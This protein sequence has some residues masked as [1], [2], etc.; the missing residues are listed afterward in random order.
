MLSSASVTVQDRP[1]QS[2]VLT[3][4]AVIDMRSAGVKPDMTVVISGDRILALGK[5]SDVSAPQ[6]ATVIDASGKFLIPGLWDM[7]VHTVYDKADDTEKTLLPLFI[8]NGVTGIRN[9]GSINSLEQIKRWRTTSAEGKLIGPRILIGQQIDGPGG[10]NV[11]FVYRVKSESEAQTAVQRVHREGFDFVKVYGRLTREAYFAVAGESKRLG[12]PFVGH[13]PTAVSNGEASDVGQKSIEHLEGML[14]SVSS[15]ELRIRRDWLDY[16]AKITALNGKA[17]PPELEVRQFRII[18]EGIDTFDAHKAARLYAR[19]VQN[20]TYQCPTLVIHQAWGS[21]SNPDFFSDVR[22]RYVPAR[23]R[24]SVNLYL[25]AARSWPAEKKAVTER[26]FEYRMRM[27][28][29]MNCAGVKLLAGTDTAYGYPVGG[30]AL[31]DE[32][33]L[34]VRAGLSPFAALQTATVNPAEF[35]GLGNVLGTIETGK[36]ADLVLLDANP[37]ED[38]NNTKKISAVVAQGR[39]LPKAKIQE[40]LSAMEKR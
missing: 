24:R 27:V 33:A 31:H 37:L 7:H 9:L 18:T 20:G 34:L 3:H 14:F 30:F 26:L 35:L 38:I 6:N 10:I 12:I 4:V 23:Q 16:E 22:L 25:D 17:A 39:Y 13:V 19:F 40:M 15:D 11:P 28:G 1:S 2:I 21:L 5:S 32:L 8:A 29:E 36:F